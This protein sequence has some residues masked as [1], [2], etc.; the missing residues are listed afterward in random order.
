MKKKTFEIENY[1]IG[2]NDFSPDFRYLK[3]YM[4]DQKEIIPI[5]KSFTHVTEGEVELVL[6]SGRSGTGKSVLINEIN[7]PIVE[8]KGYFAAGK[9]RSI[10]KKIPLPWDYF[11]YQEPL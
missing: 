3:N 4:E 1:Q 2:Q 10:Q 6:I 11:K 5:L 8:Y 7:K 9:Y